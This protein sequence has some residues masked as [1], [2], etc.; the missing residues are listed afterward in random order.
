M[1]SV[2]DI[3]WFVADAFANPSV[4][5]GETIDIAGDTLTVA[6][7]KQGY[8]RVSGR[9]PSKTM[10]PVD[11]F[12]KVDT[13]AAHCPEDWMRAKWADLREGYFPAAAG[14]EN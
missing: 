13:M 1:I 12:F 8:T 6:E 5:L 9:S 10:N 4:Y 14:R 7:I 3:G 2:D 11:I